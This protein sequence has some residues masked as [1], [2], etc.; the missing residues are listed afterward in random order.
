MQIVLLD[1][2]HHLPVPARPVLH[3]R[4]AHPAHPGQRDDGPQ[5]GGQGVI[6]GRCPQPVAGRHREDPPGRQPRRSPDGPAR[7]GRRRQP[8]GGRPRPGRR[9]HPHGR[10]P[11]DRRVGAHGRERAHAQAGGRGRCR[12]RPRRPRGHG[13]HEHPGHAG[14]GRHPRRHDRHGHPGGQHQRDAPGDRGRGH[15]ADEADQRADAPDPGPRRL[16]ADGVARPGNR[17]RRAAPGALPHRR[18]IH[19]RRHPDGAPGDRHGHPVQGLP[20]ARGSGSHREAA[21]LG[22]DPR[23]H[24]GAQLRQDRHPHDEPDDRRPAGHR[25]A[26]LLDLRHRLLHRGQDHPGRRTARAQARALP[27]AD[28]PL[29]GCRDQGRRPHRRPERG[30]ARRPRGQGRRRCGPDPRPV[31]A[32]GDPAVRRGLQAHGHLPRLDR[33]AGQQG[34]PRLHQG[35]AGPAPQARRGRPRPGRDGGPD[36]AAARCLPRRERP[37]GQ[38]GPATHG[39]GPEGLRRGHVRPGRRPPAR[40]SRA[41]RSSR[42]SASPI[43]RGRPRRPPSRRPMAPASTSA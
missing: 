4:H 25:R 9:P 30:L 16:R 3:R 38:G 12:R 28:G 27:A 36:R 35:R 7:P 14:L 43:R 32:R 2:G 15:A 29:L 41:S 42:S 37:D 31:P 22:R 26:A 17:P 6:G 33:R 34:R 10:D 40:R 23:I 8:P 24:L 18:R 21:P 39:H 1:R 11:R 20:D 5:A 13:V 19:D